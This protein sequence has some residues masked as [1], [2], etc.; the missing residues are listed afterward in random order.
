[1][2]TGAFISGLLGGVSKKLDEREKQRRE[3]YLMVL[4]STD[5]RITGNQRITD[6]AWDNIAK[7][8][9]PE[10]KK[11][12]PKVK[13]IWG[14]LRP[15]QQQGGQLQAPQ[16]QGAAQQASGPLQPPQPQQASA[17]PQ[18]QPL[19]PLSGAAGPPQAWKG[20]Q[21]PPEGATP[22]AAAPG[23]LQ[24]P[25]PKDPR[26]WGGPKSKRDVLMPGQ[27]PQ[28]AQQVAGPLQAP[29]P[30]TNGKP[31]TDRMLL[32][33]EQVFEKQEAQ[34]KQRIATLQAEAKEMLG[35][36]ASKRDITNYV[37]SQMGSHEL[38]SQTT[39]PTA[40]DLR[41][42]AE[43]LANDESAPEADRKAAKGYLNSVKPKPTALDLRK[44]AEEILADPESSDADKEGAKGYLDSLKA[45]EAKTGNKKFVWGKKPGSDTPKLAYMDPKDPKG[46]YDP[47]TN[48]KLDG[49]APGATPTEQRLYGAVLGYYYHF[50]NMGYSDTEARQK[51]GEMFTEREGVHLGRVEQQA[52]IDSAL[53]GISIGPGFKK[54]TKSPADAPNLKTDAGE[55]ATPKTA[56]TTGK[57]NKPPASIG[58]RGQAQD[59][60]EQ[61][62]ILYYLG[63]V[64]GTQKGAGK[65]SGVRSMEGQKA[66]AK[67]TGLDPM[68]LNAALSED[69]ATAK[70]LAETVQRKG[71]IDRLQN[72]I[73]KHGAVLEGVVK[74]I[75][76]TGS[77]LLNKP[78]REWKRAAAGSPEL[79]RFEIAINAVQREYAYLTAGGAQSRAMLPVTT[80]ENM[81][82]II[83]EDS[84][85]A[86]VNAAISQMRTE[87]QKE[88]EAMTQTVQDMKD[89]LSSGAVGSAVHGQGGNLKPPPGATNGKVGGD[90]KSLSTDELLKRLAQ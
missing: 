20:S 53:S 29:K 9:S 3:D 55:L 79:K 49:F 74:E 81:Q 46:Y 68:S 14:K 19:Q 75:Q 4:Q 40:L 39:K 60:K 70:Q 89:S 76:D 27:E 59:Q 26:G 12:I 44:Q 45:K 11:L 22:Q 38:T 25:Q 15:H 87:A 72:T 51:A 35:P 16:A 31:R 37:M 2:A 63:T 5:P 36:D 28:G 33:D 83:S 69:K 47:D 24:A 32:T 82:K 54:E 41:R 65:A 84:T 66:L 42:Q 1:M 34:R 67:L 77:P 13:E 17:A 64:M 8:L 80:S 62:N 86:E 21:P 56:T 73:D 18:Q 57:G 48:E 43:A 7:H 10:N 58:V 71:A 50:R 90:L 30:N 61:D 23:P 78:V 52:Q 85:L 6:E 88:T